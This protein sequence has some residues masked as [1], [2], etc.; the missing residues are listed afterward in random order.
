VIL[1]GWLGL[2]LCL[3]FAA[4]EAAAADGRECDPEP[5]N[6]L[7]VPGEFI[8]CALDVGD[9][10]GFR[11]IGSS[12]EKVII[13]ATDTSGVAGPGVCIK[14]NNPDGTLAQQ[15]CSDIRARI[16]ETLTG[17]GSYSIVVEGSA[18]Q[19]LSY[20]LALETVAPPSPSATPL[21][22]G[23]RIEAAIDSEGDVD[24]YAFP[25]A[26]GSA[27][28][29]LLTDLSGTGIMCAQLFRPD[30]NPT[31]GG[32]LC[33]IIPL[34]LDEA[35]AQD[36][37]YSLVVQA[38]EGDVETRQYAVSLQCVSGSCPASNRPSIAINLTG[39]TACKAG[40]DTLRVEATVKNPAT[41]AVKVEIKAGV[42]LPDGTNVNLWSVSG[43]FMDKHFEF[44]IPAGFN[45]T[46]QILNMKVPNGLPVGTYVYETSFIEP[47][48]GRT[49]ARD[50]QSFTVQ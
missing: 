13:Y 44:L 24:L 22:V 45:H 10:D 1:A 6:M 23:C 11:F 20:A 25:S 31:L 21:C 39:C 17:D 29:I 50:A 46:V 18:A 19:A 7:I 2:A 41:Q 48:L 12:G 27:F 37:P 43:L 30:G 8:N 47:Q 40:Q 49:L 26:H 14:L 3:G 16:E 35:M 4:H 42:I 36:G 9:T 32:P 5:T 15:A 33:G 38:Q 34:H 28:T